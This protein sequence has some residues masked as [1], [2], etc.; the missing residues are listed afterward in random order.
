MY[1]ERLEK[2]KTAAFVGFMLQLQL[3]T[4]LWLQI[5]DVTNCVV[6][7]QQ[8]TINHPDVKLK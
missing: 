8:P 4:M 2:K 5:A 3:E 6:Q 7:Q 1:E